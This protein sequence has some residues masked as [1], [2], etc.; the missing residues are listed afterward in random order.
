MNDTDDEEWLDT[1]PNVGLEVAPWGCAET[2]HA[3]REFSNLT[4]AELYETIQTLH[5]SAGGLHLDVQCRPFG[6]K[7]ADCL[8]GKVKFYCPHAREH[9]DQCGRKEKKN[10]EGPRSDRKGDMRRVYFN[11]AEPCH[12]QFF[13]RRKQESVVPQHGGTEKAVHLE[14]M[15]CPTK[16]DWYIDGEQ[17]Q[18]LEGRKRTPA[19]YTHTGHPRNVMPVGKVTPDI[20]KY[21]E[22]LAKHQVTVA[23]IASGILEKY[24]CVISDSAIY[25]AIRGLGYSID[26]S[27]NK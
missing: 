9:A 6:S 2:F 19:V 20:L 22:E 24:Q 27:E 25:Y 23:S 18:K 8:P 11:K 5:I 3:G 4:Y 17:R 13:V 12:F 26:Y 15:K 14:Y 7:S 10:E 21:I 16:S 1:A